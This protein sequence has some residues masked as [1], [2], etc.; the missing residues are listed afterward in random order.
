MGS[1]L[2]VK[3]QVGIDQRGDKQYRCKR[4]SDEYD[5]S[6]QSAHTRYKAISSPHD[7]GCPLVWKLID[8][9]L[10]SRVAP[11][12]SPFEQMRQLVEFAKLPLRIRRILPT[13]DR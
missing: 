13:R 9:L 12:Q 10:G 11:V 3:E 7:Q 8:V 6:A 2:E 4:A 1:D 5:E